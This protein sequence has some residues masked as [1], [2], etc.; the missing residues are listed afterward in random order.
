MLFGGWYVSIRAGNFSI[1]LTWLAIVGKSYIQHC[2]V[3]N[4]M[5]SQHRHWLAMSQ[6][7]TDIRPT[8]SQRQETRIKHRQLWPK[9]T[10]GWMSYKC[11][12]NVGAISCRIYVGPTLAVW[13]KLRW[14]NIIIQHRGTLCQH[15]PNVLLMLSGCLLAHHINICGRNNTQMFKLIFLK[16]A[17]YSLQLKLII[18]CVRRSVCKG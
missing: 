18:N 17:H 10:V 8:F 13:T 14:T 12:F 4:H 11:W 15:V 9:L 7:E 16:T 2:P 1:S 5:L 3:S 6:S